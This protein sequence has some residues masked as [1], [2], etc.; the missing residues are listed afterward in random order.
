VEAV[1]RD[2]ELGAIE[3]WLTTGGARTLLIDGEPGIGKTTLW[4]RGVELAHDRSYRVLA[5]T[6]TASEAQLA[7]TGIRDLV[8]EL[9][10]DVEAQLPSPQR[11]ALAVALLREEPGAAPP[12]Q[13]EVAAGFLGALRLAAAAGPVLVAVDDVQWLDSSSALILGFA[14]RRLHDEAVWLLLSRRAAPDEAG[15]RELA[16]AADSIEITVRPLS[17]GALRQLLQAR[18]GLELARPLLRQIHDT[19][20][21]N[22]FFALELAR[23]LG[24]TV[25]S[26]AP[27]DSLPVPATLREL[28]GLRLNAL[29]PAT[30]ELLLVASALSEATLELVKEA[31]DAD[32][33]P[34]LQPAVDAHVVELR[35]DRVEFS[36]PLYAAAVFDSAPLARR[37]EL[38]RRLAAVVSAVEERAHHLARATETPDDEVAHV[39]EQAS[40]HAARRGAVHSAADFC[41]LA[42]SFSRETDAARRLTVQEAEY[43]LQSGDT[44][45]ARTLLDG[46]LPGLPPSR[47]RA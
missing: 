47:E 18:L 7:Y 22:P 26:I 25:T 10:L 15:L 11:R 12:G 5:A 40:L 29:P 27:G 46:L 13:G 37:R 2:A 33:F 24:P 28:V 4:R 9:F 34:L 42:R 38:H 3:S 39:L 43:A 30:L 21:G 45:R 44:P 17:S 36:H 20:A 8:G 41:A 16:R 31:L 1:G 19:S 32:P 14:A 23:A 35:G 6:P